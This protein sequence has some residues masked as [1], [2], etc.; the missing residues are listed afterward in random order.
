MKYLDYLNTDFDNYFKK[1]ETHGLK[2]YPWIG[3]NFMK[4]HDK[5]LIV[6]ESVYNWETAVEERKKA[7]SILNKYD[8]A[9][10]VA[11]EHGIESPIPKRKF[12]RNIEKV[13]SGCSIIQKNKHAEFWQKISFHEFVQRPMINIQE[14]PQKADYKLGASILVEIINQLQVKKC[15]FLGTQWDKYAAIEK[16]IEFGKSVHFGFKINNTL[17]KIIQINNDL[18]TKIYFIKHP[19]KFFS[20]D[21][22]NDFIEHN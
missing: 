21:K 5:I 14:R 20:W 2:Y 7:D 18:K 9:R 8:F 3:K 10:I 19:S 22:W 4:T 16:E 11:F 15:V 12:A 17:P 1:I 6:G 13:I